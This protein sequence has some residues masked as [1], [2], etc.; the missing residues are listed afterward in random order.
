MIESFWFEVWRGD[1]YITTVDY[2][3]GTILAE[4]SLGYTFKLIPYY[5]P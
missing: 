4:S 3:Q 1:L 2:W 5:A